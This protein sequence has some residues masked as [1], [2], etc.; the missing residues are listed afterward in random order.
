MA[1]L[2][3]SDPDAYAE[4]LA[5][6]HDYDITVEVLDAEER[7]LTSARLLDGQINLQRD[8]TVRRTATLS[9]LD[10][11]FELGLDTADVTGGA[12]PNRFIR[13]THHV[14][15]GN[16]LVSVPC[17]VGPISQTSRTGPV[18][19]V[20]V[21]DKT[22]R[23]MYGTKPFR[24][25]KGE[26]AAT[27]I[28]KIMATCTGEEK[29][30][31]ASTSYRLPVAVNVGWAEESSPWT[32]CAKIASWAR[33]R[34]YYSCDG[35]LTLAPRASVASWTFDAG[36]IV[37]DPT[38]VIDFAGVVNYARVT[39]TDEAGAVLRGA[40]PPASHPLSPDAMGRNGVPFFLPA[41]AEVDGVGTKPVRPSAKKG[42]KVSPRV[43]R[44]FASDLKSWQAKVRS[45]AQKAQQSADSLL[46]AGLGLDAAV[47]FNAVPVF[48]LDA[49]DLVAVV[50]EAGPRTLTLDTASI[51]LCS[52]EMS[53]GTYRRV[54]KPPKGVSA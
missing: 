30:R 34:L 6:S 2:L 13:I 25:A 28:R 53:V 50:T 7:V 45:A 9:L 31:L 20:E 41:L 39:S 21:Q 43:W 38:G 4:R 37:G 44:K 24:V 27:A 17:M 52:G 18:I 51:P 10:P 32:L 12:T 33:L 8:S 11:N 48:H 35:Y 36:N 49:D 3:A 19:D 16:E 15:V 29:F 23:A 54:S 40:R 5:A 46:E 22:A 42:R 26:N 14:E 1:L 47:S